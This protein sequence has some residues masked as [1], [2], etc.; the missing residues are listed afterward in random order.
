MSYGV[1]LWTFANLGKFANKSYLSRT[2]AIGGI[3]IRLPAKPTQAQIGRAVKAVLAAG[4]EVGRVEIDPATGGIKVIAKSP[5]KDDDDVAS[6]K[7]DFDKWLVNH[8]ARKT[9]GH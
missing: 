9:Q 7:N 5:P 6:T 3:V 2:Q 8:R 1:Q 4:I